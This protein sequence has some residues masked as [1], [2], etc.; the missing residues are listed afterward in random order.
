MTAAIE[1]ILSQKLGPVVSVTTPGFFFAAIVERTKTALT[2]V[3]GYFLGT[4]LDSRFKSP[5][6]CCGTFLFNMAGTLDTRGS[7]GQKETVKWNGGKS[8][9]LSGGKKIQGMS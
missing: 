8:S 4:Q 6:C 3:S 9:V 7:K 2:V 5:Y 1:Y